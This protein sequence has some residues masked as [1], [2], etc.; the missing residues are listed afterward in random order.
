MSFITE[1]GRLSSLLLVI[2]I[3]C[4]YGVQYHSSTHAHRVH[5]SFSHPPLSHPSPS[6]VVTILLPG[7]LFKFPHMRESMWYLSF[8]EC[9]I[10]LNTMDGPSVPSVL[11][12]M[13]EFHSLWLH[14][15]SLCHMPHFLYPFIHH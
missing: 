10:S 4:A 6:R 8:Y 5:F 7:L 9:L 1:N 14:N 2:G 15:T 13:T 11:L 12:Q 3:S